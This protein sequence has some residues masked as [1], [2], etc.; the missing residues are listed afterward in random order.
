[1]SLMYRLCWPFDMKEMLKMKNLAYFIFFILN[2]L[3]YC[4]QMSV[5]INTSFKLNGQHYLQ[6]YD[7]LFY[8][9]KLKVRPATSG[10]SK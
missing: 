4:K 10:H 9:K 1:M 3:T 2:H 5:F 6:I 8:I 7:I